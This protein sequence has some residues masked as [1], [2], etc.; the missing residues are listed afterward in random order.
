MLC[1]CRGRGS[2]GWPSR[3]RVVPKVCTRKWLEFT[4][5]AMLNILWESSPQYVGWYPGV[6]MRGHW[7]C[8][9]LTSIWDI[10]S[11][12]QIHALWNQLQMKPWTNSLMGG[13]AS[14]DYNDP[15]HTHSQWKPKECNWSEELCR[16]SNKWKIRRAPVSFNSFF[17]ALLSSTV[18]KTMTKGVEK[19][20]LTYKSQ[21]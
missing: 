5:F 2:S 18:I 10:P 16:A 21:P 4:L 19:V 13:V 6:R 11:Q 9:V 20:Y 14:S 15:N 7:I 12:V 8:R 3:G 17:T 1:L